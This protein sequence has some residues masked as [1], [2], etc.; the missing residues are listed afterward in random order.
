M[1]LGHSRGRQEGVPRTSKVPGA[2]AWNRAKE[3]R[4]SSCSPKSP[5]DLVGSASIK[6]A[7]QNA[8]RST[9]PKAHLEHISHVCPEGGAANPALARRRPLLL[10]GAGALRSVS[11][12]PAGRTRPVGG[13]AGPGAAAPSAHPEAAAA[14]RA[15]RECAARRAAGRE[16][17]RGREGGSRREPP[18]LPA[19]VP[20]GR[21]GRFEPGSRARPAPSCLLS[22][23]AA[24]GRPPDPVLSGGWPWPEA[25]GDWWL[26]KTHFWRILSAGPMVR[27][28]FGFRFPRLFL[29]AFILDASRRSAPADAAEPRSCAGSRG[30]GARGCLPEAGKGGQGG[31]GSDGPP[32]QRESS[33]GDVFWAFSRAFS[34]SSPESVTADEQSTGKSDGKLDA[35]GA[36]ARTP[37]LLPTPPRGLSGLSACSPRRLLCPGRASSRNCNSR[38]WPQGMGGW[39][40]LHLPSWQLKSPRCREVG[41]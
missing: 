12:R 34:I 22:W 8:L 28:A 6:K 33:P 24:P 39:G 40:C 14:R 32:S 36:T 38:S 16:A 17:R 1:S 30:A 20:A 2:P 15:P 35:A 5:G 29:C 26:R 18:P 25:G 27:G 31:A 13:A 37:S 21:M 7:A 4:T 10:G 23:G 11:R 41:T 19:E 3:E 9:Q